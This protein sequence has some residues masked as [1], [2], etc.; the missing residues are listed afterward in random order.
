[1]STRNNPNI[2]P[3]ATLT[4]TNALFTQTISTTTTYYWRILDPTTGCVSNESQITLNYQPFQISASNRNVCIRTSIEFQATRYQDASNNLIPIRW[5]FMPHDSIII[6]SDTT[7]Y[8][9][10]ASWNTPGTKSVMLVAI[11][12]PTCPEFKQ[13]I[14]VNVYAPPKINIQLLGEGCI[15]NQMRLSASVDQTH[16]PMVLPHTYT[17]NCDQ[18]IPQPNNTFGPFN[19]SWNRTGTKTIRLEVRPTNEVCPAQSITTTQVIAYPPIPI[20]C[21][22]IPKV[23]R[24]TNIEVTLEHLGNNQKIELYEARN[25]VRP[26][27]GD[28]IGNGNRAII[29]N[30]KITFYIQNSDTLYYGVRDITSN[31]PSIDRLPI[32]LDYDPSI[33]LNNPIVDS[34]IKVCRNVSNNQ[35]FTL[36][37][38]DPKN[39]YQARLYK[40]PNSVLVTTN[41]RTSQNVYSMRLPYTNTTTNFYLYL[42]D[43]LTNCPSDTVKIQV[44]VFSP[45][46][47]VVYCPEICGPGRDTIHI[48][49]SP[50]NAIHVQNSLG[51]RIETLL[52]PNFQFITPHLTTNTMYYFQAEALELP[53]CFSP[54][55]EI[56]VKIKPLPP[57][58]RAV[59]T[60]K[61][62]CRPSQVTFTFENP[63]STQELYIYDSA[64][65]QIEAINTSPYKFIT[66]IIFT[67]TTF[68]A[69]C[70]NIENGCLSNKIPLEVRFNGKPQIDTI[71]VKS[72]GCQAGKAIIEIKHNSSVDS[73][74]IASESCAC[75][76]RKIPATGTLTT[77]EINITTTTEF[78]ITPLNISC[79]AGEHKKTRVPVYSK[80]EIQ[81]RPI[82]NSNCIQF[83]ARG[84]SSNK[85]VYELLNSNLPSNSHGQFCNLPAGNYIL[86]VCSENY[87]NFGNES[88]CESKSVTILPTECPSTSLEFKIEKEPD[89]K[90]GYIKATWKPQPNATGYEVGL[91]EHTP[92]SNDW[93]QSRPI[94][95]PRAESSYK[96]MNLQ[97]EKYYEA[98]IRVFCEGGIN[99]PYYATIFY[100]DICNTPNKLVYTKLET[101]LGKIT[102][103]QNDVQE[104]CKP[105]VYHFCYA[106]IANASSYES[107]IQMR[108]YT[109]IFKNEEELALV[110]GN[111]YVAA[112]RTVCY[113]GSVISDINRELQF[114][115]QQR[116]TQSLDRNTFFLYPNP[117]RGRFVISCS[118]NHSENYYLQIVSSLGNLLQENV[119]QAQEGP[120]QWDIELPS[121]LSSGVYWIRLLD[122][123]NIPLFWQ[124]FILQK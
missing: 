2:I 8:N 122:K 58:P 41:L 87:Q 68:Y 54:K 110:P 94:F 81:T 27:S 33:R 63:G 77:F 25:S 28:L 42:K 84:D 51:Q 12:T 20:A 67:N 103:T 19:I 64:H 45:Q 10:S 112:A 113:G 21:N 70:Y 57:I 74:S 116:K 13:Q 82:N 91:R 43:T 124:P 50:G 86:K 40:E 30:K 38:N 80:I 89:C 35:T 18:C 111:R 48:S 114:T 97:P 107:C 119:L 121:S 61:E 17:W 56:M 31:C 6:R 117:T 49:P 55:K 115:H 22:Y 5:R 106:P 101:Y 72:P 90:D 123:Q 65:N 100:T 29:Q 85:Y 102:I 66:P 95:I 99:S 53:G 9:I 73:L 69:A 60:I 79:G 23:C 62:I 120:N 24:P 59:S 109:T 108:N 83:L 46:Q 76:N 92:G 37:I 4:P 44:K 7:Q 88:C 96:F 36:R 47:P 1:Q 71:I 32:I 15:N 105:M 26:F 104:N 11:A 34:V 3:I 118:A 52:P 75:F 14:V 78:V 93:T 16:N 39:T 98:R